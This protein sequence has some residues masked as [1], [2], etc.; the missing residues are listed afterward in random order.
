ML[1]R[2]AAML[3]LGSFSLVSLF[4]CTASP[5]D[6]GRTVPVDHEHC[7]A[8][9]IVFSTDFFT[10]ALEVNNQGFVFE[11]QDGIVPA[12]KDEWNH[13]LAAQPV[14]GVFRSARESR[15]VVR[16]LC[17]ERA[18]LKLKYVGAK[19][20]CTGWECTPQSDPPQDVFRF[21][22]REDSELGDRSAGSIG[23]Y[24]IVLWPPPLGERGF[25]LAIARPYGNGL[26]FTLPKDRASSFLTS[27]SQIGNNQL[28]PG[29]L[30][31]DCDGR[32]WKTSSVRSPSNRSNP[33]KQTTD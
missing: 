32:G 30:E 7:D 22:D 29:L 21:P 14:V 24:S 13:F 8:T 4:A 18:G 2:H 23:D 17:R 15:A 31:L 20:L 16:S 33:N 10:R 26:V 19:F 9:L 5:V 12:N 3:L 11:V 6:K 27:W 1:T 28:S 25:A